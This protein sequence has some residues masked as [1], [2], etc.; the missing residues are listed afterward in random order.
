MRAVVLPLAL[1]AA[2][3]AGCQSSGRPAAG[4]P[5]IEPARFVGQ[6]EAEV[7]GALGRPHSARSELDTQVWQYA[8]PDCV[9]DFF[10]AP[11]AGSRVVAHAEARSRANGAPLSSCRMS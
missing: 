3:V 10:L 6:T 1:L 8:G 11:E 7:S 4:G 9:V 5:V 2:T